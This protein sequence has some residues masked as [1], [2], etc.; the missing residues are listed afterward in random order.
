MRIARR[1]TRQALARFEEQAQETI[2]KIGQNADRRKAGQGAPRAARR[3][4][5]TEDD[6]RQYRIGP[7][8]HSHVAR[9]YPA[10]QQEGG[11]GATLVELRE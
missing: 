7:R 4:Q 9:F 11:A 2:G 3:F 5:S 1:R 10:P 8:A 6:S